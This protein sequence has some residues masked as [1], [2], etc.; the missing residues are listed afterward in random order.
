M[1][2]PTSRRPLV[3]TARDQAARPTRDGE[4]RGFRLGFAILLLPLIQVPF[5]NSAVGAD[6]RA[7]SKET[8]TRFAFSET[9]MGS[10]F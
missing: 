7:T 5:G 9:H 8:A 2:H 6:P 3:N 4:A 1:G 10:T